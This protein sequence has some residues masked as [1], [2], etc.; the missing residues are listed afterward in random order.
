[1]HL[2]LI[3]FTVLVA[4]S[5]RKYSSNRSI[6]NDLQL[7]LCKTVQIVGAVVISAA[8]ALLLLFKFV[9]TSIALICT[10]SSC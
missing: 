7:F 9:L 10:I 3:T 2:F 8:V 4:F 1:M 6:M 5:G